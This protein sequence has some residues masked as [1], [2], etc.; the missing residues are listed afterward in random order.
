MQRC[1]DGKEVD[2]SHF[3]KQMMLR[4]LGIF[5]LVSQESNAHNIT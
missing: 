2:I 4:V 5:A 1:G 3:R